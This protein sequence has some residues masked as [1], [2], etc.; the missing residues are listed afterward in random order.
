MAAVPTYRYL[1]ICGLC[2]SSSIVSRFVCDNS[3]TWLTWLPNLQT[4]RR[5]S[6][7][8]GVSV[9]SVC[10]ERLADGLRSEGPPEE[11]G[12]AWV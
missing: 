12:G 9:T 7:M 10:D 8:T 4:K 2:V 1:R 3:H 6:V 5:R 11:V